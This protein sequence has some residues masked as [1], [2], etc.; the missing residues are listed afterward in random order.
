MTRTNR[1]LNGHGK[2]GFHS[3]RLH[4][5][6][7]I[8][9][10][11]DV[12]LSNGDGTATITFARPLNSANYRVLLCPQE[13][14][15]NDNLT[16]CITTKTPQSFV[17]NVTSTDHATPITIAY[18]VLANHDKNSTNSS[19]RFGFHS[20][21]AYFKNLQW[22]KA[23]VAID[24]GGDGTDFEVK[25]QK[26]MRNKPLIFLSFDDETAVTAGFA[27]VGAAQTHGGFTIDVVGVTGPT[28]NV[29]I[30]WVAFDPG[31]NFGTADAKGNSG[32]AGVGGNKEGK[33]G[34]H[35]G[36]FR[37]KNFVGGIV[38]ATTGAGGDKTEA[39]VLAQ[40]LRKTPRVFCF[41]QSPVDDV[42]AVTY[43]T[44]AA[45]SGFTVGVNNSNTTSN[46]V[47]LG[48]LAIDPEWLPTKA[49]E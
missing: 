42:T 25:F 17:I 32:D 21:H 11:V 38:A 41:V 27:Y 8:S 9:G 14:T 29:D 20:G 40:M 26:P 3:G 10:S 19:G 18:L 22:G 31:F 24:G 44:S 16:L 48:W 23:V 34:I 36:N 37:A 12:T 33:F 5:H 2:V 30:T 49:P 1:V 43:V 28:T 46:I 39:V 4:A 7:I 47:Y 35:S 6:N 13:A 45:I 15:T